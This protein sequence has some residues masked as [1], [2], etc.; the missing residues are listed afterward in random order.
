MSRDYNDVYGQ[1]EQDYMENNS[2]I[3]E[4]EA[5]VYHTI[6]DADYIIK[7]HGVKFFV[8]KL[9]SYSKIALSDY[10]KKMKPLTFD[11]VF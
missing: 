6:K 8:E 4:E 5:W 9:N 3:N 7:R 2:G 10:Y 11:E 1:V